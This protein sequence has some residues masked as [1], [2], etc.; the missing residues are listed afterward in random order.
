MWSVDLIEFGIGVVKSFDYRNRAEAVAKR[1]ELKAQ[2]P[3]HSV[4]M[5][6]WN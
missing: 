3:E 1:D 5:H 4:Y 2:Y 6:W